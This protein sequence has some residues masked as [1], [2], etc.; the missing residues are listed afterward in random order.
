MNVFKTLMA[1]ILGSMVMWT[2][3]CDTSDDTTTKPPAT[4]APATEAPATEAPTMQG[5]QTSTP[6]NLRPKQADTGSGSA[7]IFITNVQG[8]PYNGESF[9]VDIAAACEDAVEDPIIA[10]GFRIK[11]DPTRCDLVGVSDVELGG[12]G[13]VLGAM[14]MDG[15]I[16]FKD[17][18]AMGNYQNEKEALTLCRL[19]FT[20][21]QS[22]QT[23]PYSI[24]VT[25]DPDNVALPNKKFQGIP[26]DY[27]SDQANP[28][29]QKSE[30]PPSQ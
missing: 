22:D 4:E 18:G 15:D 6:R 30:T 24:I 3:A 27:N 1:I 29:P 26:H 11:Y 19:S 16:A 25:E 2:G 20:V 10:Y 21:K 14:E 5:K 9:T 17:L 23:G 7:I 28:L 12:A 13:P 8:D